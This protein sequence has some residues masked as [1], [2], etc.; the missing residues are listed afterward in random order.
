MKI[1][2]KYKMVKITNEIKEILK[3]NNIFKIEKYNLKNYK[4][5]KN[6]YCSNCEKEFKENEEFFVLFFKIN[7][8]FFSVRRLCKKCYKKIKK[9]KLI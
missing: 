9:E 3:N 8:R 2:Q 6:N 4:I 1:L 7:H 5:N